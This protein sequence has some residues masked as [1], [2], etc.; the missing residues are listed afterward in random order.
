MRRAAQEASLLVSVIV[1]ALIVWFVIAD[2]ENRE[3]E[4]RLGFSLPVEVR[5][6]GS[7]LVVVSEPL[8]VTVTV[9]GREADVEAARPEHFLAT[10][11]MRNRVAGQ[12]SLPVRVD[13]LEGEVRVRAV[14][15]ET[16]VVILQQSVEREVPVVVEPSN[17]PPLGFRVGTPEVRPETA[18][19]SGIAAEV[20]AV[21]SVVAR[22][23]LGGA[24]ASV[25]RDVTLEARTAAGGS[26][27]Q[28]LINPRFAQ[29]RV[30]IEQEVFRKTASIL[31]DVIGTPAEGYRV[32]TVSAAPTTVEVL[33]SLDVLDDEV[34]VSTEPIQIGGRTTNLTTQ[35]RLVFADGVVP[36]G[37]TEASIQVTIAIEP[38]LTTVEL[39]IALR[40]VGLR[41]GLETSP[42]DP[43]VARV[44]LHGPVTSLSELEG[45]LGP[46]E[47][48][49]SD[50]G[51]GRHLIAL[52][53]QPPSEIEML[54]IT[55]DRILITV[56]P[57]QPANVETDTAGNGEAGE[58]DDE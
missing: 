58:T 39:P 8:P 31:P 50:L 14:Q 46:L 24:R 11:S 15:P 54:N 2:T 42:L 9:F 47:I 56:S 43:P 25:E 35:A 21:D 37:E 22:L 10:V 32:R 33:V 45:P 57:I 7:D 40:L 6:L 49:I 3:I 20:E 18:L 55:P 30:P 4:T 44:T 48:D 53:W 28:V 16:V 17:L 26:V 52:E 34:E 51:A 5:E 38:V 29:V 1:L 19:V 12:H 41:D 36:A 13:R 27:S 23:D